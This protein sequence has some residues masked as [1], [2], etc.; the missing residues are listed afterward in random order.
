MTVHGSRPMLN[1]HAMARVARSACERAAHAEAMPIVAARERA[2]HTRAM[3]CAS[4]AALLCGC[5]QSTLEVPGNPVGCDPMGGEVDGSFADPAGA[6]TKFGPVQASLSAPDEVT[7]TDGT[8]SLVISIGAPPRQISLVFPGRPVF[9]TT[10][11]VVIDEDTLCHAGRFDA[12]F[13]F[14]GEVGGWFAVP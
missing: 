3:L 7:L 14:H 9:A 4:V 8:L 13:Q 6:S 1:A 11:K 2:A 5:T 10:G 12:F